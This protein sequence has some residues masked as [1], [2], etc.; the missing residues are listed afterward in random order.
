MTREDGSRGVRTSS[1]DAVTD[2]LVVAGA[3]RIGASPAPKNPAPNVAALIDHTILKPDAVER[4]I[5][6]LSRRSRRAP[7]RVVC[8]NPVW[9]LAAPLGPG[10]RSENLHGGRLSARRHVARR[11]GVR[12]APCGRS[13]ATEI[14]MVLAVGQLKSGRD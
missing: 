12:N 1:L 8:A 3:D 13:R 10:H 7:L 11:E 9:R 2:A 6:R 4:D 14:D 5:D